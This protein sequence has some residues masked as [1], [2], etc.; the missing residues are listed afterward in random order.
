MKTRLLILLIGLLSAGCLGRRTANENTDNNVTAALPA[1]DSAVAETAVA[2]TAVAP[3]CDSIPEANPEARNFERHGP[4]VE[5]D[6]TFLYQSSVYDPEHDRTS[7]CRAYIEM[8]RESESYRLLAS[9][10]T[11]G[12]NDWN[13]DSFAQYL[14]LLKEQHPEPLPVYSLQECPRAWIPICSYRGKY[15]VDMLYWYPIW[16]TESLFVRQM[17][18]GP[19]PSIIDAFERIDPTHY[20]FRTTAGYLDI[21]QVDVYIV[22]PVRKIAVFAF[23]GEEPE[24]PRYLGLYAPPETVREMDLIEWDFTESPDGDEIDWDEPDY[25]ALIAGRNTGSVDLQTENKPEE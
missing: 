7:H 4:F 12:Y 15:Y 21:Q 11:P 19:F 5:N 3:V 22:D 6:T 13:R 20:C 17:M 23:S 25:E 18:D 10:T 2:E 8:N 14:E 24:N 9:C 1:A 16:I